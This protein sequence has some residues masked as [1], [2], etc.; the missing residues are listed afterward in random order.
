MG[1]QRGGNQKPYILINRDINGDKKQVN[2]ILGKIEE[3]ISRLILCETINSI[4][5]T[6]A[7]LTELKND[8]NFE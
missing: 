2:K 6:N 3:D 7:K 4:E 8:E 5:D 1:H